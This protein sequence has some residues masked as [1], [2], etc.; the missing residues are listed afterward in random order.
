[1]I[2]IPSPLGRGKT[3]VNVTDFFKYMQLFHD[4]A[5]TTGRPFWTYSMCMPYA[6][7]CGDITPAAL[8]DGTANGRLVPTEGNCG[9][10]HSPRWLTVR[11]GLCIGH[12]HSDRR[13]DH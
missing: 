8:T 1:M 13:R 12:T 2:S 11:R 5:K 7:N 4:E 6:Y 3:I 10:R 9:L